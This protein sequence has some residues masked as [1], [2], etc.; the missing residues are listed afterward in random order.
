MKV[1]RFERSL[2]LELFGRKGHPYPEQQKEK[3]KTIIH[4]LLIGLAI[5]GCAPVIKGITPN[6]SAFASATTTQVPA[7]EGTGSAS[8]PNPSSVKGPPAILL[9]PGKGN[10]PISLPIPTPALPEGWEEFSSAALHIAVN[11]PSN[12]SVEEQAN[13]IRFRS[14]SGAVIL[15]Q[16][17]TPSDITPGNPQ[18]TTLI[19]DYGQA[20]NLCGGE[21]MYSAEFN[22]QLKDGSSEALTIS[23]TSDE[24]LEVYKQMINLLHPSP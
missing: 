8:K 2:C 21:G 1:G 5:A 9:E 13:E 19:T 11:Y 4:I 20:A 6:A 18:C 15:F 22:L 14:P 12:W 3:M 23:T 7:T 24:A 10:P 16:V 17:H